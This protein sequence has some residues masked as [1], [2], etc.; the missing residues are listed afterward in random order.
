M[1]KEIKNMYVGNAVSINMLDGNCAIWRIRKLKDAEEAKSLLTSLVCPIVSCVGHEATASV[2]SRLLGI[3]V[4]TN[5]ITVK[6]QDG[7]AVLV[8]ALGQRLP[9]GKII[10]E[11][12]LKSIQINW[13][14]VQVKNEEVE[15]WNT[16]IYL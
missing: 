8:G 5:R 12:E 4:P 2:F 1:K 3:D 7:D 11:E 16:T 10:S 13:Y 15:I 14:L 9:E 6:L